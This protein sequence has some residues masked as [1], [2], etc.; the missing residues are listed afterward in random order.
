MFGG[1]VA[2]ANRSGMM[3]LLFMHFAHKIFEA[4]E[5]AKYSFGNKKS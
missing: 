1:G 2:F 5:V 3:L 4:T